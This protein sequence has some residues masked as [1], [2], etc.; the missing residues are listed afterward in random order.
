MNDETRELLS[1]YLDGALPEGERR[2]LEARLAS[3]A[4]LRGAL[5]DLRSV[6][7]AVKGRKGVWKCSGER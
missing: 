6:S 5:E 1:A 2:A 3:S 4:E 7:K